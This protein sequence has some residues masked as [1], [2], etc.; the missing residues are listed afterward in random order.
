MTERRQVF[1]DLVPH[2]S[3]AAIEEILDNIDCYIHGPIN[4]IVLWREDV[5]QKADEIIG[6][7]YLLSP[8]VLS[9]DP[10][11]QSFSSFSSEEL[12]GSR[13]FWHSEIASGGRH[14][15]LTPSK[16]FD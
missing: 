15:V 9:P 3:D 11:L 5:V 16:I 13:G 6:D 12:D 7:R 2:G 10:F 8:V 14:L 4:G 1:D